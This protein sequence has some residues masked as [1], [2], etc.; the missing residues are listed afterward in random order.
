M[1]RR[2]TCCEVERVHQDRNSSSGEDHFLCWR[3][4]LNF[5]NPL[6]NNSTFTSLIH[7][8]HT[9]LHCR[10]KG[11]GISRLLSLK[12]EFDAQSVSHTI[13]VS[14]PERK[15]EKS[16]AG[17]NC[18]KFPRISNFTLLSPIWLHR[19]KGRPFK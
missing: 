5:K 17:N 15:K 11:K 4:I 16:P 2:R 7:Q 12:L 14:C 1:F 6:E 18:N 10:K 13:I 9:F 3:R 19:M 8:S